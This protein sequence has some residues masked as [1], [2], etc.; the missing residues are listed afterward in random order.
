[1]LLPGV[2]TGVWGP[3]PGPGLGA[4]VEDAKAGEGGALVGPPGL[5]PVAEGPGLTWRRLLL[6]RPRP[7]DTRLK[8][9]L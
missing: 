4:G 6:E 2:R 3:E 8:S 5:T 1:M 7:M 9:V